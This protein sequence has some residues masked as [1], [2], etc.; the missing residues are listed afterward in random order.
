M[1]NEYNYSLIIAMNCRAL[2][3]KYWRYQLIEFRLWYE[4]LIWFWIVSILFGHKLSPNFSLVSKLLADFRIDSCL[5]I[6]S[7][8]EKIQFATCS[9][10]WNIHSYISRQISLSNISYASHYTFQFHKLLPQT[11]YEISAVQ[12]FIIADIWTTDKDCVNIPNTRCWEL[13][14][15]LG[16]W[17]R[18]NN[19]FKKKLPR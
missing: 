4:Y 8:A 12:D 1:I 18:W 3:N 15:I 10:K 2:W 16:L 13:K 19:T 14:R 17:N 5:E 9:W 6:R 11:H 7:E